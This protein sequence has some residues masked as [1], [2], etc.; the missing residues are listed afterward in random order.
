MT[1]E[2]FATQIERLCAQARE[3]DIPDDEIIDVLEGAIDAIEGEV[4]QARRLN[5][6]AVIEIWFP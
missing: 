3:S 1:V 4:D 2:E 5:T 6:F